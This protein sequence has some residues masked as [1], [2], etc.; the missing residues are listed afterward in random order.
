[1][2]ADFYRYARRHGA[3]ERAALQ[4]ALT[5]NTKNLLASFKER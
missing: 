4:Y 3:S 1:M 5:R 2:I